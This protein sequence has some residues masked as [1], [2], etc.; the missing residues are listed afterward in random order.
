MWRL[1]AE[2][3]K[4]DA[5]G[6]RFV[7]PS[8]AVG[9]DG[10]WVVLAREVDAEGK[11]SDL[12][13]MI[14]GN[15]GKTWSKPR[16]SGLKGRR[17]EIVEL[18]DGLFVAVAEGT[19]GRLHAAYAWDELSHFMV[20]P[21]ACGYC[22]R[23]NGRKYFAVGSGP[24]VAGELNG[25]HQVPLSAAEIAAARRKAVVRLP[26]SGPGFKFK[27]DWRQVDEKAGDAAFV[28]TDRRAL[29]EVEFEGEVVFLVHDQSPN[30]RRM[31]TVEIDGRHYPMLSM[32]G[33]RKAVSTCL[34]ADLGPGR[35]KLRLRRKSNKGEC[36]ITV[37][38]LEVAK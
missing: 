21:L 26:A 12:V 25:L 11:G 31:L 29:M 16:V 33:N 35:H 7:E 24:D 15:R 27:N 1:V 4:P 20:Q 8:L 17:P 3:P 32:K 13:V 23:V 30:C 6:K 36:P 5:V 34:A 18:L 22:V 14:S 38:A 2:C 37:R 9:R 19:G 10:R 28:S